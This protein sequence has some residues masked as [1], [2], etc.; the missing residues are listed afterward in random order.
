MLNVT[1]DMKQGQGL[2]KDRTYVG[3]VVDNNDPER[4]CRVKVQ[5]AQVFD[6][7]STDLLP[8]ALPSFLS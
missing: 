7:I 6:G 4:L 3:V 8:W 5:I 1:S 2:N